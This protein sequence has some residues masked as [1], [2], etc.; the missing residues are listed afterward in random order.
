MEYVTGQHVIHPL[1]PEWGIGEVVDASRNGK[2]CVHF[3]PVGLKTLSLEVAKLDIV[4]SA[5]FP[6]RR[7]IDIEKVRVICD[8]FYE[9]MTNNRRNR[10]DGGLALHIIRDLRRRGELNSA[11]KKRLLAWCHTDGHVFQRGVPIA[12][13]ICT[14]IFGNIP[15]RRPWSKRA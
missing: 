3:Q 6:G 14:E 8:E 12:R 4:E 7:T 5:P 13:Q 9:E 11:T 10:D 2:V 15:P 1:R